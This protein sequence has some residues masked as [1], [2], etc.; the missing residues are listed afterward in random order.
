MKAAYVVALLFLIATPVVA[1][2][3]TFTCAI[4]GSD[5]DGFSI[6]ATNSGSNHKKCSADCTVTTSD[7]STKSWS[8]TGRTVRAVSHKQ[9]FG[10]ESGVAG[11]PL[12]DPKIS[13][14]SCD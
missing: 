3:V 1:E 9:W 4:M 7:G 10:G 5:N 6:F 13:S 12:R 11:A 2:D 14:S 8:Y